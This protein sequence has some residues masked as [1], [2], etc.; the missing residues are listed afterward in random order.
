MTTS[1][2]ETYEMF[3]EYINK[4][5]QLFKDN[6]LKAVQYVST[7]NAV[8][9]FR[10]KFHYIL[11]NILKE[12]VPPIYLNVH[13]TE[14]SNIIKIYNVFTPLEKIKYKNSVLVGNMFRPSTRVLSINNGYITISK[15]ALVTAYS[16]INLK[17]NNISYSYAKDIE[18]ML[19]YYF[20]TS[21][22]YDMYIYK[23]YDGSIDN[24]LFTIGVSLIDGNDIIE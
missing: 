20:N 16:L 8:H 21:Y 11:Y 13:T 15:P 4:L 18:W 10:Y 5:H 3:D 22:N 7:G 1:N 9:D 14:D 2:L 19:N 12:Y 24:G 23:K 17:K 6:V